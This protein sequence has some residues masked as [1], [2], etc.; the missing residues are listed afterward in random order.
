MGSS[1]DC[2]PKLKR[3]LFRLGSR[4]SCR[5]GCLPKLRRSD[6]IENC[7]EMARFSCF[8]MPS[9]FTYTYTCTYVSAVL[10]LKLNSIN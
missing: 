1:E 10:S 2:L 8:A 3:K 9:M 7:P 5:D 4:E 6:P